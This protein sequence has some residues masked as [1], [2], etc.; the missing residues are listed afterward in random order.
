M[1]VPADTVARLRLAREWRGMSGDELAARRVRFY[2]A[3]DLATY[4]QIERVADIAERF[5][6]ADV[7]VSTTDIIELHNVQQYVEA[8]FFPRS[9]TDTQRAQAEARIP[10]IRSAVARFFTAIDDTNAAEFVAGVDYIY[11]ADLLE[12]LGR[13]KAFQR[14]DAGIMLPALNAAGVGL[15]EML[16][17]RKL[18]EAY[19][20]RLREELLANPRNAEHLVRKYLQRDV[21][22][23]THLPRS[24]TPAH[25]R[26]LL[27]GYVDSSEANPNFIGLIETAPVSSQTGVDAKLKLRAKRR[28]DR[29]V[30]AL[31]KDNA[32]IKTGCEVRIS[33]T[34][35]EPVK[36][37]LDGMVATFTYSDSWL[38][39]TSDNPSILNNFQHL[40][41]F[42][43]RYALLTLPAYPADLGVFERFLTTTGRTEYHIGAAFHATDMSSLLQTRLYHHY[44]A[45]KDIDLE[46]V[47]SWFFELYLV[48][49]FD[50]LNFSFTPSDSG[51]SYLQKA[52][53]LFAEMESIALQFTLYVENGE[54]DRDL[55]AITS[56]PVRYKQIP[57]TLAEKYVYA[58]ENQEIAGVLH[59]LFSDQSGLAY[60]S[61]AL[62]AESAAQ[63]LIQNDVSYADFLDHQKPSV[64]HLVKLG[65]LE[66]T[67]TRVQIAN[68]EQFL[69]LRSL[70]RTQAASYYHLSDAGRAQV[71][72]MVTR[73][74]VT[75][76]ASLL[77]EAEASYFNYYLNKV[78]FGNGPELRNKYLHGSQ[79]TA[80]GEDAHFRTYITALRLII[81]LVIKLN[82]D[83]CLSA[84]EGAALE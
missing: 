5:D 46:S 9:Y 13:N 50:A 69:V 56:D 24:L 22:S 67:G 20:V 62:N 53:H 38:N 66:D 27:Q 63:L 26:E 45:S 84:A 75:C 76:R 25:A 47:I 32:G 57:S 8:G 70:F 6:P 83:F 65:V 3:G 81:A 44:L 64:D 73:G 11:H 78:E 49:E 28:K 10:Q 35:E 71:D 59:A 2:G 54:L 48:E 16:A 68:K 17:N 82:D 23:E 29:M 42:A 43:D 36:V 61:D 37:E 74:W 30:E 14:C 39:Q 1:G 77:S 41:E 60:I 55:L 72:S 12:L 79:A 21:G 34:Q 15:G 4:W 80:D 51:S 58:N 18:V 40:F 7:P 33:D 19:D 31:F 52:R